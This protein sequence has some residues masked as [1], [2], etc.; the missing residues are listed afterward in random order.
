MPF[1]QGQ[2]RNAYLTIEIET[3]CRHC[4]R[5]LHITADSRG[6]VAAHEP[7][8]APWVFMPDVDWETFAEKT[9]IDSY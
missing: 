9:I 2:L 7:G 1:V 3:R 4:D 5:P 8:A 6:Q